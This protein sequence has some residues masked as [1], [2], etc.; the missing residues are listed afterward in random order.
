MR[1]RLFISLLSIFFISH[2]N[3][4]QNQE[5]SI[6]WGDDQI[7]TLNVSKNVLGSQIEYGFTADVEFRVILKYRRHTEVIARFKNDTLEFCSSKSVMNDDLK[8]F[9]TSKRQKNSYRLFQHPSDSSIFNGIIKNTVARMYFEEPRNLKETYAE[10]HSKFCQIEALGSG[11]YKLH[12]SDDK[13][14]IY[15]YVNGRLEEVQVNRTWFDIVFRRV[16]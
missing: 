9:H 12:L 16:K 14:N 7:G 3:L 10:G 4:A 6:F 1:I 8:D 5:Y 11:S 15:N 13:T 2:S